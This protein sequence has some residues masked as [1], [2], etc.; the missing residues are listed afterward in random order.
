MKIHGL[1]L[2][3]WRYTD[4]T[5]Y[6]GDT[7]TVLLMVEIHRLYLLWWRYTDCT[8]YGGDGGDT[9]IVFLN[10]PDNGSCH[11][12]SR[13]MQTFCAIKLLCCGRRRRRTPYNVDI[14]LGIARC[15]WQD[16]T[17]QIGCEGLDCIILAE[18][19]AQCRTVVK[20]VM[21]FLIP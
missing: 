1:Y 3:W 13:W 16:I 4:C 9:Q 2:L 21:N 6:G 7:Q 19:R 5:S 17:N 11:E 18:I 14:Q 15:M 20:R 10:D 8:S 12:M